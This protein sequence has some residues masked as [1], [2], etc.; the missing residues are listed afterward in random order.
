MHET[1]ACVSV[2]D[3]FDEKNAR[4]DRVC[5]EAHSLTLEQ[6]APHLDTSEGLRALSTVTCHAS[7]SSS[8]E[9][10]GGGADL[11]LGP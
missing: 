10:L 5:E 2:Q 6:S 3:I 1:M 4:V 9:W 7:W 11:R 8:V